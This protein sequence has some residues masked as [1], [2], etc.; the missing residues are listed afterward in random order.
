MKRFTA[1]PTAIQG[2]RFRY[3]IN[4][5]WKHPHTYNRV[6]YAS[7]LVIMQARDIGR[8]IKA[9]VWTPGHV[10]DATIP[11]SFEDAK[12][13]HDGKYL[14]DLGGYGRVVVE[15]DSDAL[16]VVWVVVPGIAP[17]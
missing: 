16:D 6:T 5:V 3:V 7:T 4:D 8:P 12:G 1:T 2:G 15:A 17:S 11:W 13:W 14:R 9:T 10:E